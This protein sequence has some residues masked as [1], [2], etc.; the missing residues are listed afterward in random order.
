MSSSLGL[1][2]RSGAASLWFAAM[3]FV[4]FPAALLW[5]GGSLDWPEPGAPLVAGAALAVA[6]QVVVAAHVAAFVRQGRG[7]HAPFEPPRSLVESGLYRHL[8][9]P[10]YLLYVLVIAGEALA[11]RS[12]LLW[13]YA[14]GFWLL[15]HVYV[16]GVEEKALRRR[17]GDAYDAYCLRVPRWLPR[18]G[19]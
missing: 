19:S 16:V 12:A 5:A 7:T 13:A 6:A 2:L 17:F 1:A 15:A 11:F 8:R 18:L 3:F 4:A 9:N 10:M 14:G